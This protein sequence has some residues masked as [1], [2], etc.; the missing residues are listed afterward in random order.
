MVNAAFGWAWI[1]LGLL[2]GLVLGLCFHNDDWLGGYASWPRRLL[3]LGHVAMI[4]LGGLNILF[5]ASL[6]WLKL[7]TALVRADSRL[8]LLGA[9]TMPPACLLAAWK[10]NWPPPLLFAVPV[11]CLLAAAFL[12]TW[13]MA[14]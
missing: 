9:A 10:R 8:W 12:T 3:R 2:T 5:A 4:A 7:P 13:G 11:A 14:R 1:T 6:V